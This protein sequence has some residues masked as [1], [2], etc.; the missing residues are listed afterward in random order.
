[1]FRLGRLLSRFIDVLTVISG[2]AIALM[3]LHVTVDVLARVVELAEVDSN[4]AHIWREV[5]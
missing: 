1:M 5:R 4:L 3:M 2:L